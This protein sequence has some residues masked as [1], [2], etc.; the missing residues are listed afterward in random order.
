[1]QKNII[2]GR[3]AGI[4]KS[5]GLGSKTV[6]KKDTTAEKKLDSIEKITTEEWEEDAFVTVGIDMS[7]VNA[8]TRKP[9]TY[10]QDAWRRMK[11]NPVA[12]VSLGVIFVLAVLVVIGPVIRGYDYISMVP[13][14]KNLESSAKYWWGT[15]SLGRDLFSRVWAGARVSFA[16][17][18]SC[19]TIQIV[20]GCFYGGIMG[21]F[22]GWLD[23]LMMRVIEI[24]SSIPSLLLT[25]VIMIALGNDMVSLLVAMSVTSWCGT[26]RQIRG[27]VMQL[28]ESEYIMAAEALGASPIWI[29][30]RHLIPNTMGLL[31]LDVATAIPGYIFQEAGLSFLGLGLQAPAIS[32]GLLISAG[33]LVMNSHPNQLIYPA[34]VL[35][36]I[37]LAFNLF[38]DGLRDAL[39]PKLRQ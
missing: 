11:K 4:K 12:M 5:V 22:G 35:I 20:V 16:V 39:D 21:Y 17:A 13:G 34:M 9:I 15:D 14:A 8:V 28:R 37:V 6:W 3:N 30:V 7:E 18:I 27:Q 23:E 38:G 26:A 1:M 25:I 19:T 24:L 29:L 10:W 31:I 33:Q 36:I 2:L 32:I